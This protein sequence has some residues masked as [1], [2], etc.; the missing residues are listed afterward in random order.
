M[1]C[2]L[3]SCQHTNDTNAVSQA[4]R[5]WTWHK[6]SQ[7]GSLKT[8]NFLSLKPGGPTGWKFSK[9]KNPNRIE[10]FL[11]SDL[12]LPANFLTGGG[13][14]QGHTSQTDTYWQYKSR[15]TRLKTDRDLKQGACT[16]KCSLQSLKL[17]KKMQQ[18]SIPKLITCVCEEIFESSIS[19][20][21]SKYDVQSD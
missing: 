10:F 9:S 4:Q 2:C 8:Q 5:P 18:D 12:D 6:Y 11:R 17:A 13:E 16:R 21:S 14:T 3:L 19:R 15:F 7:G 20:M 1:R